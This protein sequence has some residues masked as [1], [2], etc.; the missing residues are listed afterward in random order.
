MV[1]RVRLLKQVMGLFIIAAFLIFL[2]G[3]RDGKPL[4]PALPSSLHLSSSSKHQSSSKHSSLHQSSGHVPAASLL[5]PTD[6]GVHVI[7][8]QQQQQQDQ[9]VEQEVVPLDPQEND[10]LYRPP[11]DLAFIF[12]HAKDNFALQAKLRSAVGSLLQHSSAPLRLHLITDEDGFH[13]ASEII[14]EVQA[15]NQLDLRYVKLVYVSAD[16]FVSEIRESVDLLRKFL[17]HRSNAYY[18]DP[19]FFFSFFLHRLLPGLDR[20]ILMDVDIKVKGDIAELHSHFERFSPTNVMGMAL[21]QTPSYRHMLSV[22]RKA[23][24]N[25]TLGGPPTF[26][27]SLSNAGDARDTLVHRHGF[28]GYNSGV[29]LMDIKKLRESKIIAS[30]MSHSKLTNLTQHYNFHGQLGDQDLYTLIA[31]DYPDVFYTLPCSW[32]RQLCVWWRDHGYKKIFNEYWTCNE[33]LKIIHG[34]CKTQIPE[35]A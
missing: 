25:T 22:Y 14:T 26:S 23:H 8:N 18:S 27:N 30:Y 3:W 33:E 5:T 6:L 17:T 1:L 24:P 4:V 15:A 10:L 2:Y 12:T 21:E 7:N 16:D 9:F 20:V 28:P 32:N 11:L 35:D 29:V 19:L 31:F 13:I 34:N